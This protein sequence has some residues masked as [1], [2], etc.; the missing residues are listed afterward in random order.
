M[1]TLLS[2]NHLEAEQFRNDSLAFLSGYRGHSGP[3]MQEFASKSGR[4]L[5]GADAAG[6]TDHAHSLVKVSAPTGDSRT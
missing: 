1:H 4:G 6:N 5:K 2:K 3:L